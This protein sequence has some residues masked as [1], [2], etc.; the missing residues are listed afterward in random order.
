MDSNTI[1]QKKLYKEVQ[2]FVLKVPERKM[3]PLSRFSRGI[4]S[5]R[6]DFFLPVNNR[7]KI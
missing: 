4:S 6:K 5:E 7:T 2:E 3:M 1:G